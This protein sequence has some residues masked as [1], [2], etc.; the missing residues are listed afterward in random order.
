MKKSDLYKI[1][2]EEIKNLLKE[3]TTI[4]KPTVKPAPTE[5]EPT[6][7]RRRTLTPP[8]E[9]PNTKPKALMEKD[10]QELINKITQRFKRLSK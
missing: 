1:I 3:K 6:P 2:K 5:T 10:E 7:T 8:K 4:T 9:A